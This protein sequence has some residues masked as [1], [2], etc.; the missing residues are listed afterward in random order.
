MGAGFLAALLA[1]RNA[2]VAA[3]LL[4][5]L[6]GA[7]VAKMALNFVLHY[8]L[9]LDGVIVRPTAWL[10]LEPLLIF[11]SLVLNAPGFVLRF[12][13]AIVE[14]VVRSTFLHRSSSSS[15]LAVLDGGYGAYIAMLKVRYAPLYTQ[16]YRPR[17]FEHR[18]AHFLPSPCAQCGSGGAVTTAAAPPTLWGEG[19]GAAKVAIN[20]LL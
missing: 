9:T 18:E 2:D 13:L 3:L 12:I 11:A 4:E 19:A 20:P 15:A 5:L 7:L 17:M 1:L 16:A 10:V 14:G 6:G 8:A